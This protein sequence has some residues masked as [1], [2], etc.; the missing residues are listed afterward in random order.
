[1][2]NENIKRLNKLT[3]MTPKSADI[4]ERNIVED[5]Q[6]KLQFLHVPTGREVAFSA[7]LQTFSESFTS[8][9]RSQSVYGRMDPIVN[10]RSTTRMFNL[11]WNIPAHGLKHAE[12]NHSKIDLLISMLYPRYEEGIAAE[13]GR[14]ITAGPIIGLRFGN[15]IQNQVDAGYL[16]GFLSG[17]SYTPDF[18]MGAF[19]VVRRG[20]KRRGPEVGVA[21]DT[22]YKGVN[23]YPKSIALAGNFTVLHTHTPG[24]HEKDPDKSVQT[25]PHGGGVLA[26]VAG[27]AVD[28]SSEIPSISMDKEL[29]TTIIDAIDARLTKQVLTALGKK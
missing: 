19:K 26:G 23:I 12:I 29:D 11:A 2:P 28:P 10:F 22:K 4:G 13:Q 5:H 3:T 1:V 25:F 16:Y 27:F 9:W 8:D 18:S 24:W 15:L 6:L 21:E 17:L 20:I 7:Y 14:A